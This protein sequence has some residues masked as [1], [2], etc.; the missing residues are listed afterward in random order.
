VCGCA[1]LYCTVLYSGIVDLEKVPWTQLTSGRDIDSSLE[2]FEEALQAGIFP[3]LI[4]QLK[5]LCDDAT[6]PS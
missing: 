3:L 1:V 5:K 2:A 4:V 6:R